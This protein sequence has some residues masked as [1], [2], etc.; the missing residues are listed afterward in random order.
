MK[1]DFEKK[2]EEIKNS[3]LENE[4]LKL[5]L[6]ESQKLIESNNQLIK[7]L[8]QNINESYNPYKTFNSLVQTSEKPPL[9]TYKKTQDQG[10]N[11]LM[12][13]DK[14]SFN[15]GYQ[16]N[17]LNNNI[18]FT[19]S[20]VPSEKNQTLSGLKDTYKGYSGNTQ[21]IPNSNEFIKPLT[22][23]SKM[24]LNSGLSNYEVKESSKISILQKIM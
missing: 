18:N 16:T 5:K 7:Y 6:E 15:Q 13:S 19:S 17:Q 23:F 12:N 22:N 4:N 8:N 11:L 3:K 21:E 24:N 14:F 10:P 2:E 20:I 9:P 1:K